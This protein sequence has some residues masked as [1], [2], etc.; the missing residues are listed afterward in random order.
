MLHPPPAPT[1]PPPA[2]TPPPDFSHD[3]DIEIEQNDSHNL[4]SA[5]DLASGNDVLD[6][7]AVGNGDEDF[8]DPA[9]HEPADLPIASAPADL[10]EDVVDAQSVE[11]L[12]ELP[13]EEVAGQLPVVGELP[14]AGGVEELAGHATSALPLD[15]LF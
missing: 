6:V 13:V 10:P 4:V 3:V 14:V 5:H 12:P 15:D 8:G 1:P 11:E 2:P 7:V 9:A